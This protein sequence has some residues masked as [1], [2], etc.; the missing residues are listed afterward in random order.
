MARGGR[1]WHRLA[2][3]AFVA[4]CVLLSSTPPL[5]GSNVRTAAVR[6]PTVLPSGPL[7]TSEVQCL[8]TEQE[9]WCQAPG[10]ARPASLNGAAWTIVRNP[11]IAEPFSS[12]EYEVVYDGADGYFLASEFNLS[13]SQ[14]ST[15]VLAAS[16]WK[17]LRTPTAPPPR[18]G[19]VLVYDPALP[20]VLLFGGTNYSYSGGWFDDTWIYRAGVWN[21]FPTNAS[22]TPHPMAGAAATYD[23]TTRSVILFGGEYAL[24]ASISY[25]NTTWSF[26][27]RG[28]N[29]TAV[30]GSPAP[31]GGYDAAATFDPSS[32][33]VVLFGGYR[34]NRPAGEWSNET[35]GF[36]GSRWQ[37]LTNAS[38]PAPPLL[39]SAAFEN[40]PSAQELVLWGGSSPS[41][42][43]PGYNAT[44]AYRPTGWVNITGQL[45]RAPPPG[46]GQGH[47]AYDPLGGFAGLFLG[48]G[49][50]WIF[51]PPIGLEPDVAPQPVDVNQS[52]NITVT[53]L[54]D[55]TNLSFS[56]SG[57]PPGCLSANTSRLGC[58]S[59]S[60]GNFT[61]GIVASTPAGDSSG[62]SITVN[63]SEA[64]SIFAVT[65]TP[66]PLTLGNT[67]VIVV[68]HSGGS[69]P[70]VVSFGELP[71]GCASASTFDLDCVPT[72]YGSYS[73]KVEVTDAAGLNATRSVELVVNPRPTAHPLLIAPSL[74]DLGSTVVVGT[75]VSGGTAPFSF[76]YSGLP[77]GCASVSTSNLSCVP[78]AAGTFSVTATVTDA[79]G[80]SDS[81]AATLTVLPAVS[82]SAFTIGPSPSEVGVA[83]ALHATVTGGF[84]PYS[85]LLAGF[86]GPCQAAGSLSPTCYPSR[87]GNFTVTLTVTDTLGISVNV[88]VPLSVAPALAID[89]FSFPTPGRAEVGQTT[90]AT[91]Q[92]SGGIAPVTA[93]YSSL[94]GGDFAC[95]PQGPSQSLVADCTWQAAGNFSILV[96]LS[97]AVGGAAQASASIEVRTAV[98]ASN[99]RISPSTADQGTTVAFSVDVTGGFPHYVIEWAGLPP[100]CPG[101]FGPSFNCTPSAAGTFTIEAVVI[102]SAGGTAYA[103][104]TLTVIPTLLG[105][106]VIDLAVGISVAAVA[107][108]AVWVVRRRQ[109]MRVGRGS[110]GAPQTA[111]EG[112]SDDGPSLRVR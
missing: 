59:A 81:S 39:A 33:N 111:S 71:P 57:L 3:V 95:T 41:N 27:A 22:A 73:V 100:G 53:A 75:N 58:R 51:G 88:S 49:D 87:A 25:F 66:N 46:L 101:V 110:D 79:F 99:L 67:T 74:I 102:D 103:S 42:L 106:P 32:G 35:W 37:N 48:R 29:R 60:P 36:D 89:S 8:P 104:A 52:F 86:P 14:Q 19:E 18:S 20:G 54:S 21:E 15:W 112:E 69:P 65:A 70:F 28:W 94:S 24:G 68:N 11:G 6:A 17:Q 105:V 45:L 30:S 26:S 23:P 63:V 12:S 43:V 93:S 98:T 2:A 90:T 4:T 1:S 55:S 9:R 10:G 97:D 109:R 107:V 85:A 44:W 47:F 80:W 7:V 76:V 62:A 92:I 83:T 61:I 108:A 50:N 56:Y 38:A 77:P 13:S 31:P 72:L 91:A 78:A 64:P 40:V 34:T 96:T 82:L 5:H 84:A 16:E